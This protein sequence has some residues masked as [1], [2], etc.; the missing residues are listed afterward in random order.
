M[1]A[2]LFGSK[3]TNKYLGRNICLKEVGG[4]SGN[5]LFWYAL[6]KILDVDMH[7]Q[8]E[9]VWNHLD[10]SEYSAFVTTDLIWL[11]PNEEKKPVW[12]QLE[13]AGDRAVVPISVGL[14]A[15]KAAK[16]FTLHPDTVKLLSAMAERCVLGCRGAYTAEVLSDHGIK[17]TTVIGCPSMYLPLDRHFRIEKKD[18]LPSS[19]CVNMR[20]MYSPLRDDEL[21]LLR[22]AA[23]REYDFCEQTGH[24]LSPRICPDRKL[25]DQLNDWMNLHKMIFFDADDWRE[26]MA[27]HDF[28]MGCRFHGNVAA[29]WMGKPALFF[30]IDSRTTEMCSHFSLPTMELRDFDPRKD[31][32]YYYE[33]ADYSEFN[34]NYAKRTDEFIAFLRK[35]DLPI[36]KKIG[37][38]DGNHTEEP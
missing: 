4:N 35:N 36:R 37:G 18:T 28:S 13:L 33:K 10:L 25:Y 34:R 8:Q 20:S 12:R 3:V 17:N 19:V 7:T 21:R 2:M 11:R 27:V 29:L 23:E 22:F 5:L 38:M 14:Q 6:T 31:I 9:C 24:P 15:Q 1:K 16:G 26:F 30:T 32:G